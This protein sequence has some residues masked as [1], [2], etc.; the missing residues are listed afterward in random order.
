MDKVGLNNFGGGLVELKCFRREFW[1]V[2]YICSREIMCLMLMK[3]IFM[4][5]VIIFFVIKMN[6]I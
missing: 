1:G 5:R 6:G 4:L 3:V 2:L